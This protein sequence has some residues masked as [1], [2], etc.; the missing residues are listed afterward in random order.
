MGKGCPLSP[1]LFNIALEFLLVKAI[2]QEEIKGIQLSKVVV[3]L[4]LFMDDMILSLIDKK[5]STQKLLDTINNFSK[6]AGYKINLQ[7]SVSIHQ[8]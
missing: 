8:Q 5:N 2:I 1:F 4:S 7:K 6:E 3:K